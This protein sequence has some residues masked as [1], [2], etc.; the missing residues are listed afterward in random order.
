MSD[1]RFLAW[2][3]ERLLHKYQEDA[4]VDYMQK[5]LAIVNS[6]PVERVTPNDLCLDKN[7]VQ[8]IL[9]I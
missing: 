3:Y 1:R 2:L 6:T 4:N 9:G 8:Q 7:Q 5:L